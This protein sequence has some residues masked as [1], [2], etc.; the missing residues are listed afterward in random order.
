MQPGRRRACTRL[1]YSRL[2]LS[3][4]ERARAAVSSGASALAAASHGHATRLHS[5]YMRAAS[6]F[7]GELGLGSHSRLWMDVSTALTSYMGLQL[8]CRMSRQM[9][10]SA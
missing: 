5:V 3:K 4:R 10:P 9:P 1:L 8:F 6:E 7:A 2:R